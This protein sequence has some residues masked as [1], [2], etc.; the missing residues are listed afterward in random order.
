MRNENGFRVNDTIYELGH[1]R[2][3]ANKP[4]IYVCLSVCLSVT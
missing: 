3:N 1:K 4:R 2:Y